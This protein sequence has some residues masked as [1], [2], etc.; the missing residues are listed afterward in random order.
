AMGLFSYVEIKASRP[1]KKIKRAGNA[2][3]QDLQG[4]YEKILKGISI[5]VIFLAFA[6]MLWR[7]NY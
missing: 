3:N 4:I 7:R 5:G 6:M 1:Y 2:E